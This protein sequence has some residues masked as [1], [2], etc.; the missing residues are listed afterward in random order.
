MKNWN[1]RKKEVSSTTFY[2]WRYLLKKKLANAKQLTIYSNLVAI[3]FKE[4]LFD[5]IFSIF[6]CYEQLP[7][8][9]VMYVI[10][11][12]KKIVQ[13][14]PQIFFPKTISRILQPYNSLFPK[15]AFFW[16]DDFWT[17]LQTLLKKKKA[18]NAFQKC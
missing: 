1:W 14:F 6:P 11:S 7:Y 12:L 3:P 15:R 8:V 5:F 2:N 16:F 4:T 13:N 9:D 10:K 18:L 17:I